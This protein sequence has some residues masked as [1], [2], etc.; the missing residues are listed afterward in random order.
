MRE[1]YKGYDRERTEY[2]E[3]RNGE[4]GNTEWTTSIQ[5]ACLEV[6]EDYPDGKR[7]RFERYPLIKK[8]RKSFGLAL[9]WITGMDYSNF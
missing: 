9:N 4:V 1:Q 7:G 3:Q 2:I 8:L 5:S 6:V